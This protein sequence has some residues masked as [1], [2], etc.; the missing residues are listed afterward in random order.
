[1]IPNERSEWNSYQKTKNPLW[2]LP[3]YQNYHWIQNKNKISTSDRKINYYKWAKRVKILS[4]N[5]LSIMVIKKSK[6]A[7]DSENDCF[8][9]EYKGV[10]LVIFFF[11]LNCCTMFWFWNEWKINF[12]IFAMYS[13]WDMV[14]QKPYNLLN[15]EK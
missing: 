7:L 12:P 4:I 1:M 9:S 13:F 11:G 10:F 2:I 15:F 8:K 14:A 3:F 6:I 5:K